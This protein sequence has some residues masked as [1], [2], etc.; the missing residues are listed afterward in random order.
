MV[1][2]ELIR[3]AILWHEMWHE[4]LEEASRL[5]FGERNVDGMLAVLYPLHEMMERGPETLRWGP[6]KPVGLTNPHDPTVK[7][8]AIVQLRQDNALGTIYNMV[9][10]QTKMKYSAQAE[11]IKT[12]PGLENAVF[13]RLGGIHRNT[14]INS[15][16]LLN[17]QLQMKKR[18][19]LRFAGQIMG[20]EGYVESA[21]LGLITGRMAA[22]QARGETLPP[23]PLTTAMGSL[24]EHVTGGY[25]TGSKAKFQPMNVNYGI[26]PPIEDISYKTEDG[27]RLRG[28]EKTRHRKRHFSL[29]ALE[30]IQGWIKAG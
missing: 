8:H 26:F 13:A 7:S 3:V 21:A 10:F 6:M 5:Y 4:G 15:P 25:M 23:P 24:V 2:Q 14:F 11:I 18:K 20:V 30:D 1:S 17:S 27:K 29:R 19:D 22:A 16:K 28:K 9:G 12:I